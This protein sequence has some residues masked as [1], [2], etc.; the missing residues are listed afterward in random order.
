[1]ST[2]KEKLEYLKRK[3]EHVRKRIAFVTTVA[4]F[5]VIVSLWWNSITL[6]SSNTSQA[7]QAITMHQVISPFSAVTKTFKDFAGEAANSLM[8][9]QQALI[10]ASTTIASVNNAEVTA[11][12]AHPQTPPSTNDVVYPN[13]IVDTSKNDPPSVSTD[14]ASATKKTTTPL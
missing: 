10:D 2:L 14:N 13:D 1:M 12:T 4:I 9:A 3:P 5:S 11:H 8:G 6:N 7:D